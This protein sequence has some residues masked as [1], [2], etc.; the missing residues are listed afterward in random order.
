MAS[1]DVAFPNTD[2][3]IEQDTFIYRLC[4]YFSADYDLDDDVSRSE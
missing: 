3:E 2:V 4:V 1:T